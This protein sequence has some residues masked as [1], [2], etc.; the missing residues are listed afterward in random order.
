MLALITEKEEK[1]LLRLQ[2]YK[3]Y[4]IK[5]KLQNKSKLKYLKWKSNQ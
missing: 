1:N 2:N 4:K 5:K 3:Q